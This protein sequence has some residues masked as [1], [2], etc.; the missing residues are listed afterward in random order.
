MDWDL[1]ITD[2]SVS[3]Q[4]IDNRCY[5]YRSTKIHRGYRWCRSIF[6]RQVTLY[7]LAAAIAA[8]RIVGM[9]PRFPVESGEHA[10]S[11]YGVFRVALV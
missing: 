3:G 7:D 2:Q 8:R 6:S 11:P 1:F 9:I 4:V 10:V 5:L